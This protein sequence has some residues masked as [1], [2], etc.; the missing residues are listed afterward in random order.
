M[1]DAL[2]FVARTLAFCAA[3]LPTHRAVF[4]PVDLV[5]ILVIRGLLRPKLEADDRP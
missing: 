2:L 5:R 1:E 3:E 4:D